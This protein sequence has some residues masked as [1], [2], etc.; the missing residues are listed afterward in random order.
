MIC[1]HCGEEMTIKDKKIGEDEFGEPIYQAYAFCYNCKIKRKVKPEELEDDYDDD[2]DYEE[3]PKRST[4][5]N[6]PNETD[7]Q[8]ARREAKERY[9]AMRE[10]ED[11]KERL[12]REQREAKEDR[13]WPKVLI[14]ILILALLAVGGYFGY[15]K[16]IKPIYIDPPKEVTVDK[17]ADND[18]EDIQRET[19][20]GDTT[21]GTD[22]TTD[23][24][25]D[26]T[27]D[28]TTDEATDTTTD[29]TVDSSTPNE[30]GTLPEQ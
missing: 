3:P 16:I 18:T 9:H 27:T 14:T 1:K 4:Y 30:S 28:G 8:R 5:S 12:R 2:Y 19:T 21:D 22:E 26:S 20:D 23:E 25:T 29:S 10:A 7:K 24:T 6:I 15:M 17:D 11:E 13:V